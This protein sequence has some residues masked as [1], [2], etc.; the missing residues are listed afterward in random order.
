MVLA[1]SADLYADT[2]NS[3]IKKPPFQFSRGNISDEKEETCAC[4]HADTHKLLPHL[5]L[6]ALI[7]T[8][9]SVSQ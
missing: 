1:T 8:Q 7:P 9:Q 5:L 4:F 6:S 3:I 2:I